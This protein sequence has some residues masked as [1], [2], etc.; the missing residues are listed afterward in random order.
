MRGAVAVPNPLCVSVTAKCFFIWHSTALAPAHRCCRP[1][2]LSLALAPAPAPGSL[3][4]RP[5]GVLL[6]REPIGPNTPKCA[7]EGIG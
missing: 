4:L 2:G 1:V 3:L 6:R 7:R 5:L